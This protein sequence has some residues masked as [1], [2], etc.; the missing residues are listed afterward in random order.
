[1]AGVLAGNYWSSDYTQ[2]SL[3][4]MELS[5][6]GTT[7]YGITKTTLKETVERPPGYANGSLSTGQPAGKHSATGTL[8]MYSPSAAALRAVLGGGWSQVQFGIGISLFEPNGAGLLQYNVSGV[9]LGDIEADFG[10]A[11]GSKAGE[12]TFSL[13]IVKPI[14][15]N[16][17]PAIYDPST[18]AGF[19]IQLPTISLIG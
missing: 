2:L 8:A 7:I 16:G 4:S 11:G 19:P 15:W 10:E 6:Q 18:L 5:V 12:E 1:M 17:L 14:D 13:V 9:T 3:A